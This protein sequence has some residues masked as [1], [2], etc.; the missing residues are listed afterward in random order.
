MCYNYYVMH[1]SETSIKE[2]DSE[3]GPGVKTR[4]I[5]VDDHPLLRQALKSVLMKQQD[6]EVVAEAGDGVEA[7]NLVTEL[8]PDVVI[9]DISMPGM[10]GI[11]ATRIIH[12]EL[13]E[14]RI[15]GLSM[16]QEGE[17]A[18]AMRDAGAVAYLTK[19][20]P[21]EDVIAAIRSCFE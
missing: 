13:P 16:F 19:S 9:M 12:S 21:S 2:L 3:Q 7:V 5:V 14:I 20:G 4:I 1:D 10:N 6:F 18:R 8:V 11:Q 15:I 17:Q